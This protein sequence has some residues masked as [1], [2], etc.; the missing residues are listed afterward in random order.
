MAKERTSVRMQAQVKTLSEQGHSIR[1]IARILRL[2]RRTVRKFLEPTPQSSSD[3]GGWVET[4]DW[5][6]VRKEVYGKGTTVKQIQ[7]EVAPEVGYV[8]FWRAFREKV[9]CQAS[10]QQVTIRL[11]HK[12][13]EKTQIDFSDGLWITDPATG[14]KT[15]TQFFLGVLPFSS[16]TF[17]EFVL[18]QKLSTFIGVQERMFAFFGGVTPYLVVDNLK[19]GVH[20]ADLYDPDV[21]PTYC[22]FANH[23]GFAVLPA[24][25]NKAR[26]KGCGECHIG[27]IQ[28]GFFQQV[29]NRTFYSLPELNTAFRHDL[30]RLNHEVMKDYGVSRNQRFEE[31][32][33]QLKAL[34]P[35]AFELSEWRAAKAHP[36][37]HIQVEK[38]FYSVPFVYV[39]QKVRVRLTEKMVEVFSQDSQPLTAHMRLRG[40]GQFST[41]DFH[42]PEAKLAVAR[43]EVHHALA[44]AR[45]L[46]PHVEKL[47]G[48]LLSAQ[49]P[50]RHL[51]RVQG[52]LRLARRYPITPQALDHACQRAMVF[53]KTRL[54]Y[55]KDCALYFVTHGRRPTLA[56]PKRQSG[57][58]HL[59][60]HTA[61]SD[62]DPELSLP[63]IEEELL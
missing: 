30:E 4:V 41:Y 52:I 39:G 25:P 45:K 12:P 15:L 18:D 6:Y 31:E 51:R 8:K 61:N 43:F 3:S 27:V 62:P 55:I 10:P 13:A 20:R 22:D 28:R 33:K 47:L 53:H 16:Y 58:L 29:R 48:E 56:A 9:G 19:S 7:Q 1:R 57:T 11:D 26:D 34:P 60:R 59:H 63:S 44:Q 2:S 49:H 24:R 42:Y 23:M 17:G 40:I 36:D 5:E 32:K 46:G 54:A 35:C 38:N 21:N 37:C 50:L 14:N